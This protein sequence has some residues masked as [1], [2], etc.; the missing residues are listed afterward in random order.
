MC[1]RDR[2]DVAVT[3]VEEGVL[4]EIPTNLV[5]YIDY[6]AFG[7]DLEMEGNF[8]VTRNGVFEYLE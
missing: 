2:A 8:L 4:G 7:R 1:I 5:N 6:E 3:L